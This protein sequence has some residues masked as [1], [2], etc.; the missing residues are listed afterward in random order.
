[1]VSNVA[2]AD[3]APNTNTT[4]PSQIDKGKDSGTLQSNGL[5]TPEPTPGPEAERIAADQLYQSIEI[6]ELEK[7]LSIKV[8]PRLDQ[9]EQIKTIYIEKALI[10][11]KNKGDWSGEYI[12]LN[13]IDSFV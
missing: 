6:S 1:L 8:D 13:N 3:I 4:A 10:A 2:I 7:V 5:V 9:V 11:A 12:P